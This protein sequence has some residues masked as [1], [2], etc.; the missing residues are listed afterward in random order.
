MRVQKVLRARQL[1]AEGYSVEQAAAEARV[2]V[3]DVHDNLDRIP[4]YGCYTGRFPSPNGEPTKLPECLKCGRIPYPREHATAT[5]GVTIFHE[6]CPTP[7]GPPR[8]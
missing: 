2:P 1:V 8:K 4:L 5:A 6:K 3:A 7:H